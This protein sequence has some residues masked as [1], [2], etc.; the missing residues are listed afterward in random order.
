M[1]LRSG[2]AESRFPSA[3]N[4]TRNKEF[5]YRVIAINKAGQGEASNTVLVVP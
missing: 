3:N 2:P 4:Q 5:E 1:M